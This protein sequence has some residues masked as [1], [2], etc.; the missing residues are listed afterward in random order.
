MVARIKEARLKKQ[1]REKT[2]KALKE[3]YGYSSLMQ[4]PKLEKIVASVGLGDAILNKKLLDSSV[5]ELG[6]ITGQKAVKTKA[7]KS[8]AGFKVREGM[9]IGAKVTLR[10]Q[11]M[12]EFYDRLVNVAI[13]RI[14]D[15]RGINPNA[16]D[17]HGNYSIGIT[18]QIIFPEIDYDKIERI[19][20]L[21]ITIVTT[22]KTDGEARSLLAN[23][24]MPF[25]K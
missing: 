18:E 21:N 16:F 15:F 7:K 3:E 13:P 2:V 22:A 8:I 12:Y 9:E 24:G 20:G 1:Y 4:V 17:G 23:M 5:K 11:Y 6:Q 10:G 25:K 19:S 14:K